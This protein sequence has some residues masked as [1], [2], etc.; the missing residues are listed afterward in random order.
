MSPVEALL[1][2]LYRHITAHL[3]CL[4]PDTVPDAPIVLFVIGLIRQYLA[5]SAEVNTV[6]K[7]TID[8]QKAKLT[9]DEW[10]EIIAGMKDPTDPRLC[11]PKDN[12]VK[13]AYPKATQHDLTARVAAA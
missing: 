1:G 2:R 5:M 13:A 4:T 12:K 10:R 8:S 11:L 3:E 6:R 7:L 9:G